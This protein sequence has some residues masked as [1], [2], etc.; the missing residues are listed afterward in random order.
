[1]RQARTNLLATVEEAKTKY[2]EIISQEK[3]HVQDPYSFRCIP[4]VHGASRDIISAAR[5]LFEN[6]DLPG[7]AQPLSKMKCDLNSKPSRKVG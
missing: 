4:Q 6:L 1:M 7:C 5:E 2:N 3:K